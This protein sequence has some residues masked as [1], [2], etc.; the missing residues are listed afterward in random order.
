MTVLKDYYVISNIGNPEEEQHRKWLNGRM[1]LVMK[2]LP[3][4][5]RELIELAFYEGYSHSE[6]AAETGLPLGTIKSR[7]RGALMRIREAFADES[8]AACA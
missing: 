4:A 3:D 8:F 6:I 2:N 1:T 5:Q 7:I